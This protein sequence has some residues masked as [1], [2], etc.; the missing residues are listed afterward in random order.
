[1]RQVEQQVAVQFIPVRI[2][3][4]CLAAM[5]DGLVDTAQAVQCGT[6]IDIRPAVMRIE[7][8]H[9]FKTVDGFAQAAHLHQASAQVDMRGGRF[10][11]QLH[12]AAAAFQRGFP[13]SHI[14]QG[15]GDI[16]VG[17]RIVRCQQGHLPERRQRRLQLAVFLQG[18]AEVVEG[19]DII[20]FQQ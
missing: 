4:Q 19:V 3:L 5:H 13:L 9:G 10:W 17:D 8:D 18:H 12:G 20:G 7:F 14:V 16:A 6:D 11:P 1:M 15:G 2:D